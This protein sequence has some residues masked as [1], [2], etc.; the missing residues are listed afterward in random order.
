MSTRK[1]IDLL[2]FLSNRYSVAFENKEQ[3][4]NWLT[5]PNS[6][7]FNQS[8]IEFASSSEEAIEAVDE[9]FEERYGII[10]EE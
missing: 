9:L 4:E 10:I 5:T 2:K 3:A 6:Y 8:P 1:R 7:F